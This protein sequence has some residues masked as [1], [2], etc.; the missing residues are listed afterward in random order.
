VVFRGCLVALAVAVGATGDARG[1]PGDSCA[2]P[3]TV[4]ATGTQ[5]VGQFTGVDQ[6]TLRCH[7]GAD[8]P[9]A[10]ESIVTF[11]LDAP[12][13]TLI[14][15]PVFALR[16]TCDDVATELVCN[17]NE[18]F[19]DDM[20][21]AG[22]YYLIL[23]GEGQA[24][25]RF[26]PDAFP[27]GAACAA[28]LDIAPTG[29]QIFSGLTL[30][31][32]NEV[33]TACSSGEDVFYRFTLTEPTDVLVEGMFETVV[34]V[35]GACDDNASGVG[36]GT[37][38]ALEDL[39]A[40]EYHVVVEAPDRYRFRIAFGDAAL[41]AGA[42]CETAEPAT[43]PSSTLRGLTAFG[44]DELATTCGTGSDV[45]YALEVRY[46]Q[47]LSIDAWSEGTTVELRTACDDGATALGCG[48][49]LNF[50]YLAPGDYFVVIEN[51]A[52]G[53]Y[54]VV[55]GGLNSCR[56]AY[57]FGIDPRGSFGLED[58]TLEDNLGPFACGGSGGVGAYGF[59]I[60]EPT[61]VRIDL[62]ALD[63]ASAEPY[64]VVRAEN[65]DWGD[66]VYCGTTPIELVL[67]PDGYHV[68]VMSESG[69]RGEIEFG[70]G[71]CGCRSQDG[72]GG[73]GPVLL[74]VVLVLRRRRARR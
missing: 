10:W 29:D 54:E 59:S 70:G 57:Y 18:P 41:P 48:E 6:I 66:E 7:A 50:A 15:S 34:E 21:P 46:P 71:G 8:H 52:D 38:L 26:G 56:G 27:P 40:G 30:L 22:Q 55:I 16:T 69:F 9:A 13:P 31:G 35:R 51:P 68:I 3:I 62:D 53:P 28:A 19:G 67:E 32:G 2:E 74:G 73:A 39:P 64:V 45:V 14:E 25:L 12:T 44:G 5:E 37:I 36:C 58:A 33:D 24:T 42:T 49:D 20:L 65:C 47:A 4:P 43:A 63:G 72:G 23:E 1:A 61:R 11:T 60:G 17:R